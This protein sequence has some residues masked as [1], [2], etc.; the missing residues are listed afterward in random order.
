M[1][2][3]MCRLGEVMVQLIW[4]KASLDVSVKVF[5]DMINVYN[6]LML[7]LYIKQITLLKPHLTG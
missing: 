2:N 7:H 6:Q 3:F 4:S 5:V 1:V